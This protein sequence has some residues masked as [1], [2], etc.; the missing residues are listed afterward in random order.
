MAHSYR[1]LADGQCGRHDVL[2]GR[3]MMRAFFATA[4]LLMHPEA[5][6]TPYRPMGAIYAPPFWQ[7]IFE[8]G[9]TDI[10]TAQ[11]A[12]IQDVVRVLKAAPWRSAIVL[13]YRLGMNLSADYFL[14]YKRLSNV[15]IALRAGGASTV[16]S[17]TSEL[18][19]STNTKSP[20]AKAS[21]EIHRLAPAN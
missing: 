3:G 7:V 12:V 6:A 15:A 13:C 21:V 9:L 18:C 1:E 2:D 5:S 14:E 17:G 10:P 19:Q 20:D 11:S 16:L 4:A 8:E